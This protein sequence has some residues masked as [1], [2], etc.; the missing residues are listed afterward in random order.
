VFVFTPNAPKDL[1]RFLTG[2]ARFSAFCREYYPA[3]IRQVSVFA[4]EIRFAA[5]V[6]FVELSPKRKWPV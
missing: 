1:G 3:K 6:H 5:M 4:K 2:L